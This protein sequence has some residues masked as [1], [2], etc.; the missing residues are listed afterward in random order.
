MIT[1]VQQ[2]EVARILGYPNLSPMSSLQVHYPYFSSQLAMWQP[3]AMLLNRLSQAAPYDEVQY[4]GAESPLFG[5]FF[6]P[7]AAQLQISTPNSIAAGV[8]VQFNLGG[9]VVSYTTQAGDTPNIVS[10][11]LAAQIAATPAITASF[12]ANA[13]GPDLSAYYIATLGTDGN[14][15]NCIATS[16]DPSLLLTFGGAA[17]SQY[18]FGATSGGSVPPGPQYT[19]IGT[20]E[21]VFG[22]VPIIHTLESDFINARINLDTLK[23]E[24]WQPRQDELAVRYALLRQY[25]K[26]LADRLSV[27]LDPDLVGNAQQISQR[28]V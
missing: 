13:T 2:A 27:P 19:P 28:I 1:Q 17:P 3:Y 9:N 23:A 12:M 6:T 26:E 7:A 14:G 11:K 4:M 25:R 16:S 20:T 15:Q 22:Y 8:L 24:E 5:Q 18:A 21:T 10:A